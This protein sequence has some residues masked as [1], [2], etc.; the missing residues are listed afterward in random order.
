M[1]GIRTGQGFRAF[2]LNLILW[3]TGQR[4]KSDFSEVISWVTA[5]LKSEFRSPHPSTVAFG[6]SDKYPPLS[7][8]CFMPYT[9]PRPHLPWTPRAAPS[10][11]GGASIQGSSYSAA[12]PQFRL[13]LC[14]LVPGASAFPAGGSLATQ[15][16]TILDLRNG[17]FLLL[18]LWPTPYSPF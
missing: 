13:I 8:P 12:G 1:L 6:P 14:F 4:R 10:T 9:C 11:P 2:W 17:F 18:F 15:Y 16:W 7:P 3:M 5:T